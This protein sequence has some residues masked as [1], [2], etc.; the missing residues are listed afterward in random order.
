MLEHQCD[1]SFFALSFY[2]FEK[3]RAVKSTLSSLFG[4]YQI[5]AD[6]VVPS[7]SRSLIFVELQKMDK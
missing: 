1:S 7:V 4:F 3:A 2:F 5:P 6:P